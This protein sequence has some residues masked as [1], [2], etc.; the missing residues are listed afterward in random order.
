MK[1][2]KVPGAIHGTTSWGRRLVLWRCKGTRPEP[3]AARLRTIM[4]RAKR[5]IP[6]MSPLPACIAQMQISQ[7]F[8]VLLF[9][10]KKGYVIS[11]RQINIPAT[12]NRDFHRSS[13]SGSMTLKGG[14]IRARHTLEPSH[15]PLPR[16]LVRPLKK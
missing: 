14:R 4:M 13:I 3:N 12:G 7:I 5:Y 11:K 16:H 9:Q 8:R 6:I 2:G 10:M 1:E 15:H